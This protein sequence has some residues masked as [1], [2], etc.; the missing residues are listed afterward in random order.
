MRIL[1]PLG[2][3][4]IMYRC[5]AA[6]VAALTAACCMCGPAFASAS[7]AVSAADD[8]AKA[9]DAAAILQTGSLYTI[10]FPPLPKFLGTAWRPL[11]SMNER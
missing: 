8:A 6:V 5:T 4:G 2:A 1:Q 11:T 3:R 9:T 10:R 7:M